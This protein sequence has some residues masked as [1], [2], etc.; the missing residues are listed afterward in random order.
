MAYY[1]SFIK[2]GHNP[3]AMLG[4]TSWFDPAILEGMTNGDQGIAIMPPQQF[5]TI[6]AAYKERNPGAKPPFVTATTPAGPAGPKNPSGR[7]HVGHQRQYG[8]PGRGLEAGR[9]HD[10]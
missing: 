1:D 3:E 4:V 9:V 5:K 10:P 6:L 7:P 8:E 2:E